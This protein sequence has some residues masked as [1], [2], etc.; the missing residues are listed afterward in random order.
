M[1]QVATYVAVGALFLALFTGGCES[2][3]RAGTHTAFPTCRISRRL[4]CEGCRLATAS[5]PPRDY[6]AKYPPSM[7]SSVPV[8]NFDSSDAR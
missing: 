1:R 6:I 8:L 5:P 3:K 7:T 2:S 4:A